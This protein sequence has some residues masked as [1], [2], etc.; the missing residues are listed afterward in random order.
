MTDL[1]LLSDMELLALYNQV[2]QETKQHSFVLF[3]TYN[4][5]DV[6]VLVH[7]DRKFK[8]MQLVNQMA[9]ENTVPYLA[10]LG[11]VRYVET[12]VINRAKNVHNLVCTN[13]MV[14]TEKNEK[15]EG[16]IVMTPQAGLH[17]FLASVDLTS[18]YPSTDRAMNMSGETF[19]G[20]FAEEELAWAGIRAKDSN[21][22]TLN[23]DDHTSFALSGSEWWQYLRDENFAVSAFGTVFDQNKP[24]MLSDTLTFWFE[25]RKLLQAKKKHFA[26]LADGETDKAKK[27]DFLQQ[28]EHYDLLQLTK[29]IQLNSAYGATLNEAFRFGRREIGASITGS[30]RQITIHMVEKIGTLISGKNVTLI[31]RYSAGTH[32]PNGQP[33]GGTK[34]KDLAAIW[35]KAGN[36]EALSKLPTEPEYVMKKH[37]ETGEYGLIATGALYWPQYD[38]GTICRDIIYGDTDSCY[39]STRQ[40]NYEDAVAVADEIA[41]LV[42]ESFPA[43]MEEAFNCTGGRQNLIKA[44]REVVAS[45]GL[46]L[47]AKKKYS[48]QV[49]NLDGKDLRDKQKL[50]SMGSEIKKADTPKVVQDFLKSLMDKVLAGE[51]YQVLEKFVND[52]RGS[53]IHQAVD[54]IALGTAKQ[55]NNLDAMYADYQRTEKVG[56]GRAR[57]PGHVRAAVNYNELL[58]LYDPASPDFLRSGDKGIVFYLNPNEHGLET[59]ALPADLIHLPKWFNENLSIDLEVTENKMIDNK[60]EGIFAAIGMETPT[61][62]RAFLNQMFTF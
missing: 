48:L 6:E 32:L 11:T 1:S 20:Q 53:L 54:L 44:A 51:E 24:G 29:K 5:R 50:K 14:I 37:P 56:R 9:H 7:L 36:V 45:A 59:I 41:K 13:K 34:P 49:V 10:V 38:D 33:K 4:A 27:A 21:L 61:V 25:E 12:G 8:L 39:F 46:F 2:D 16:A 58:Q 47:H 43:F 28:A 52:Q 31:K 60:V 22:W 42:N 40:N 17:K 57:L 23:F 30:G 3:N 18:L 26:K 35:L 15:V 19:V 62:Q 55:I